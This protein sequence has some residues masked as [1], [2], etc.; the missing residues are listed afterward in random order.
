M[1]VGKIVFKDT[2]THAGKEE[3]RHTRRS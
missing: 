1:F 3:R 2:D